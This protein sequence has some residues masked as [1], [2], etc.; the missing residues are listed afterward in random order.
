MKEIDIEDNVEKV[1]E[2]KTAVKGNIKTMAEKKAAIKKPDWDNASPDDRM[3]YA[4]EVRKIYHRGGENK[5]YKDTF[6][7]EKY[8][9]VN[10]Q[11]MDAKGGLSL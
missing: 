3:R 6:L 2:K 9:N 8:K 11:H 1:E 5:E 4:E 10:F 7:G